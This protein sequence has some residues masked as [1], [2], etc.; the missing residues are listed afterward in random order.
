MTRDEA[1]ALIHDYLG[2]HGLPAI[3]LSPAH[4]GGVDWLGG[5]LWFE[6][7][8]ETGCLLW[9]AKIHNLRASIDP[10]PLLQAL[11]AAVAAGEDTGGGQLV[12]HSPSRGFF[13][14]KRVTE[15]PGTD[16]A[17]REVLADEVDRLAAAGLRWLEGRYREILLARKP[18]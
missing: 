12:W 9:W 17:R 10:T 16:P 14:R 18:G 11:E 5:C 1:Q 13:L 2:R 3:P 4:L 8:P 7:E 6:W 15:Y